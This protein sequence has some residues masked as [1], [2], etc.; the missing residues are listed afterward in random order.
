MK[1]RELLKQLADCNMEHEVYCE[2]GE[3]IVQLSDVRAP[4]AFSSDRIVILETKEAR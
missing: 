2:V 4:F 1:V 3:R